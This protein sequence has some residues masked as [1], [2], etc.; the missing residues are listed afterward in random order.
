MASIRVQLDFTLPSLPARLL[1]AGVLL[2]L[3]CPELGSEN[4]TMTTYYP[5]PSGVYAQMITT[6]NTYL[7]RDTGTTIIGGTAASSA[8]DRKL[9]VI[10]SA[11]VGYAASVSP[12]NNSLIVQGNGAIGA[13][14]GTATPVNMLDVNGRA[15]VGAYAG[16]NG[17]PANGLIVSG[18]VGIATPSPAA[19]L[20]VNGQIVAGGVTAPPGSEPFTSEGAGSGISMDDRAGG[21]NPRWVVYPSGSQLHVWHGTFGDGVLFGKPGYVYINNSNTACAGTSKPMN[22]AAALLPVCNGT[23]FATWTQGFYIE[24]TSYQN[25]GAPNLPPYGTGIAVGNAGFLCCSR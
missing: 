13:G 18:N 21:A 3:L 5:A 12:A 2:M 25:V 16:V 22:D 24:G 9:T 14:I 1:G 15:A 19:P 11:A 10:G 17:A 8:G 7:S 6:S 4:V 23:Q 20:D